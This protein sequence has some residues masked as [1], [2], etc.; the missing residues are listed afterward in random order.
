MRV[1]GWQHSGTGHLEGVQN[2]CGL[3]GDG[4]VAMLYERIFLV[5]DVL[6]AELWHIFHDELDLDGNGHLDA[7]ELSTAL[8]K[9]GK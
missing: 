5:A 6:W 2:V 9:A 4:C 7:E 3:Q 1:R 8:G